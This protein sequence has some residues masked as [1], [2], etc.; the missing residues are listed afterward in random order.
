MGITKITLSALKMGWT[1]FNFLQ[2]GKSCRG[3]GKQWQPR[4]HCSLGAFWSW[5]PLFA[6]AASCQYL[7]GATVL[8]KWL[9]TVSWCENKEFNDLQ[10]IEE[11]T[12]NHIWTSMYLGYTLYSFCFILY[13]WSNYL[14]WL[15]W[16]RVSLEIRLS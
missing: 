10:V 1:K 8:L 15:I 9:F 7:G 11:C 13:P 3:N 16:S 4:S 2:Y 12:W 5:T 6:K 14:V